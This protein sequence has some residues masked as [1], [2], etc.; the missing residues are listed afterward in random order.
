MASICGALPVFWPVIRERWSRIFVTYEVTVTR[1]SGIF[2]PRR[3]RRAVRESPP[4]LPRS[5]SSSL[6]LTPGGGGE[7][8][9]L[10][11]SDGSGATEEQ[12]LEWDPYVGD[13]KTGLGESDTIVQSPAE[14][15]PVRKALLRDKWSLI[16]MV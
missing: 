11:K 5:T 7:P 15:P 9:L 1:E 12:Q 3:P 4:P 6:E 16:N 8:G 2:V 14:G 13:S 10:P